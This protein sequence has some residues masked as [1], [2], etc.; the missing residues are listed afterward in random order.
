MLRA[1][2]GR[3]LPCLLSSDSIWELGLILNMW[4]GWYSYK[5]FV[6]SLLD[7]V[8]SAPTVYASRVEAGTA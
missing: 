3:P 7:T 4:E 6:K 8:V 1:R 5:S 2:L